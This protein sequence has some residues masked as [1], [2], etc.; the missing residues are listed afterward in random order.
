MIK[1]A[2]A[3]VKA[4]RRAKVRARAVAL[5]AALL[6]LGRAVA[7]HEGFDLDPDG[8]DLEGR[9]SLL[10][11]LVEDIAKERMSSND[12]SFGDTGDSSVSPQEPL[13]DPQWGSDVGDDQ[14][15]TDMSTGQ[16]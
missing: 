8:P 9:L 5:D 11:E 14:A 16:W 10:E 12:T 6:D 15:V 4:A 3:K 2:N 13:S 1:D 7:L